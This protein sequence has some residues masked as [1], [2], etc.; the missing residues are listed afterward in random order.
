MRLAQF[1]GTTIAAIS[2]ALSGVS[3]QA[4]ILDVVSGAKAAY[5]LRQLSSSYA[6]PALTVRR[7]S[8]NAT[9]AIGFVNGQLDTASL[10]TFAAG[11]SVMV[12]TWHDQTGN[13]FH[14]TRDTTSLQPQVVTS[15]GNLYLNPVTDLPA[16][17]FTGKSL[18]CA[19]GDLWNDEL[20]VFTAASWITVPTGS[21]SLAQRLWTIH[22]GGNTRAA[23]GGQLSRFGL[24][25]RTTGHQSATSTTS[26]TANE[27]FVVSYVSDATKPAGQDQLA[28]YLNGDPI[29]SSSSLTLGDLAV[30][31]F[32]IGAHFDSTRAFNGI[33][34]E[35]IVYHDVLSPEN[36]AAVEHAL[37]WYVPE[38]GGMMLLL[39]GGLAVLIGRRRQRQTA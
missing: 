7:A 33:M 15:L 21:D 17:R 22:D 29:W 24:S 26:I 34:H 14:M 25:Y 27:P 13:G 3:V 12:T 39:V 10:L 36:R 30:S 38:P 16:I 28:L 11:G 2:L 23:A 35:L 18:N 31:N 8:D 4:G 5:S 6:G 20:S 9:Q 32:T 1:T 19:N 37:M